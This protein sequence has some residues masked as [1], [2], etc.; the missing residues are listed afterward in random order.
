[1]THCT[2]SSD[3]APLSAMSDRRRPRPS[4]DR[5]ARPGMDAGAVLV[6]ALA[7]LCGLGLVAAI[8]L[9]ASPR[10]PLAPTAQT[11]ARLSSAEHQPAHSP[12]AAPAH[13]PHRHSARRACPVVPGAPQETKTGR[14]G[15]RRGSHM[16][17]PRRRTGAHRASS[18][19][20]RPHGHASA[21]THEKPTARPSPAA[22]TPSQPATTVPTTPTTPTPSS[23]A[24]PAPPATGGE[25]DQTS[26]LTSQQ[27]PPSTDTTSTPTGS[28]TPP[29]PTDPSQESQ[30][31]PGQPQTEAQPTP[32][33]GDS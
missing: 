27:S 21:T 8:T 15:A 11:P 7:A 25:P 12:P 16:P 4:P 14:Q 33:V 22:T 18:R 1:M 29:S 2:R 19:A 23:P 13:R 5:P 6:S 17:R 24:T 32:P 3:P 31:T 10:L 20:A 30:P 28:T 9:A 26:T